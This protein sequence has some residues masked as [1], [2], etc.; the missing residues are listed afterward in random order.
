MES[1]IHTAQEIVAQATIV[2]MLEQFAQRLL[3]AVLKNTERNGRLIAEYVQEQN[4]PP[5][6]E[7]FYNATKVI[8]RTLDWEIAPAKLILEQEATKVTKTQSQ[9]DAL[10]P[11]LDAKK[12]GE[13]AD[14]KAKADAA[15]IEQAK[16]IISGYA[17]TKNTSRGTV[18]DYGNQRSVQDSLTKVLNNAV[19]KKADLQAFT[20]WLA[21]EVARLYEKQEKNNERL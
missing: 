3:P 10:K 13:A 8:Y 7:N 9:Q 11:F 17:P 1:P 14:A 12:K 20:K 19:A 18:I 21:A 4:L 5:S 2:A 16:Q 15:S 6:A